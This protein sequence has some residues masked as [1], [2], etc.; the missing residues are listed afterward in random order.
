VS[1]Y[2]I[3]N[4]KRR[5]SI[6]RTFFLIFMS[7]GIT[8]PTSILGCANKNQLREEK[9]LSIEDVLKKHT[10]DLMSI[11]GV[12]GTAYGRKSGKDCI[13][14]LVAKKTTEITK[15]I[16]STLEGFPI[17]IQETGDIRSL[18]KP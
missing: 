15:K 13:L 1:A 3:K 12:I 16:P 9:T 4:E 10:P 7:I 8:L 14:V 11:P 6:F 5:F 2:S 18:G 17:V